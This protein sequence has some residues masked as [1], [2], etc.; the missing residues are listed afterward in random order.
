MRFLLGIFPK[1]ILIWGICTVQF[2]TNIIFAQETVIWANISGKIIGGSLRFNGISEL[3]LISRVGKISGKLNN[4]FK[5]RGRMK[6]NLLFSRGNGHLS[7]GNKL[8]GKFT[9]TL[10]SRIPV[11]GTGKGKTKDG[12]KVIFTISPLN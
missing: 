10:S 8:S 7:C 3:N 1:L 12:R 9:F 4:G 5:C 2:Q 11:R 6:I